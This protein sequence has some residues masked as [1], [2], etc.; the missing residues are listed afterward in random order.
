M[1]VQQ[2][3]LHKKR[4]D[5]SKTTSSRQKVLLTVE[6]FFSRKLKLWQA[7]YD[8]ILDRFHFPLRCPKTSASFVLILQYMLHLYYKNLW[9]PLLVDRFQNT[10]ACIFLTWQRKP[11]KRSKASW[12]KTWIPVPA[13]S[14]QEKFPTTGNWPLQWTWAYLKRPPKRRSSH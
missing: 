1:D 10:P 6:C 3:F 9:N 14:W 4:R 13:R 8:P 12:R 7:E 11:W 2:Q 5:K